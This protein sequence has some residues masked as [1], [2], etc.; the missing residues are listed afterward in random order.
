MLKKIILLLVFSLLLSSQALAANISI[1]ADLGA[2]NATLCAGGG[3]KIY[4]N[5]RFGL[6]IRPV[7]TFQ[8]NATGMALGVDGEYTILASEDFPLDIFIGLGGGF[9]RANNLTSGGFQ[10]FGG[11]GHR[12]ENGPHGVFGEVGVDHYRAAGAGSTDIHAMFG[13]RY[14]LFQA[15]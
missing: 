2:V 4:F 9:G 8:T 15:Q 1:E 7:A 11:L 12:F 14:Y 10:V 6:R 3:I 5:E 13:Y